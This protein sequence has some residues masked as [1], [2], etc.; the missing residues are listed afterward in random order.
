MYRAKQ[1]VIA[2]ITIALVSSV[3]NAQNW[4]NEYKPL[5]QVNS[6]LDEM[7][8][9]HSDLVTPLVI[10]QSVEGRDI[11]AIKIRGAGGD[12]N[13]VRPAVFI[14]GTQHAREWISPMTTMYA[15]DTLLDM[16]GT[17][18]GIRDLLD[19]VDVYVAPMVN[20]D[21]YLYSWTTDR[22]WR[23]NRR[24]NGF[25][26]FGV[27]L[28]RNW[29]YGWGGNDG[30]SNN[31][32]SNIYRGTAPFSE[33]ETQA[34]RDFYYDNQNIV[35][36]ID[37]HSYSQLI[38]Y[39]FGFSADVQAEDDEVMRRLAIE[40]SDSV[41]AVHGV[42]YDPVSAS[43]LY[44]A[45]G[46]SIDWSY[47]DQKVYSYT[48]ELRPDSFFPGFELPADEI[49]PTSE[50]AF[51]SVLDLI[52]FTHQINNGDF[53]YDGD[54]DCTDLELLGDAVINGTDKA[55]FDVNGDGLVTAADT[56]A[57]LVN[58]GEEMLPGG[59]AFL[60]GDANI[61]GRVEVADIKPW[62]ASKFSA[63]SW[64]NGD[65]DTNGQVDVSDYNLWNSR[66]F[67]SSDAAAVV[68]EPA[69]IALLLPGLFLL[70]MMRR[71]AAN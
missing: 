68:P 41:E 21:G 65:F 66:K 42:F 47:G 38:L 58:A 40:M 29:D 57:W 63:G 13:E 37:F 22:F 14:N 24:R 8:D 36:N 9:Q 5:A 7:I 60:P 49:I 23:K 34:V 16:Y 33:P 20:P 56:G 39:P 10:G 28:N 3:A 30:S 6:R 43:D 55:E 11:R 59:G 27:D 18:S 25:G 32:D 51:A 71:N 35:S 12:P 54:Y 62:N 50:E 1:F 46:V 19:Q 45:S 31:P 4:Y 17:D 69:A 70:V 15:A 61:D 64:C 52:E 2:G 48:I 53:D 26:S 44:I 67:T